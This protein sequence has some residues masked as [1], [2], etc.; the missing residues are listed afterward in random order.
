MVRSRADNYPHSDEETYSLADS[1]GSHIITTDYPPRTVRAQEH[2]Y[3]FDGYTI[4]M[5]K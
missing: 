4:K 3:D 5:L 1:C 2:V